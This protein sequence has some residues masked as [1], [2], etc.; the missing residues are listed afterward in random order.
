MLR[1]LAGCCSD[2]AGLDSRLGRYRV[3][4]VKR[5]EATA[6]GSGRNAAIPNYC[7]IV[8]E[9]TLVASASHD[10]TRALESGLE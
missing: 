6:K 8:S 5:L 7:P 10:G 2:A 4:Q 3:I 9:P 1:T